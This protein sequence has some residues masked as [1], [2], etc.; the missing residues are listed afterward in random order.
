MRDDRGVALLEVIVAA[1]LLVTLA[2]GASRIIAAAVR[3]GHASRLRAVATASAA[4]KIE[5]VRSLPPGEVAA[6][7]D[8]LDA[9]GTVVGVGIPP[10]RS[11][12]YVRRWST[13]PIDGDPDVVAV[14]VDVSTSDG[15]LR[16]RLT[17]VRAA[18]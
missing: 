16:A 1:A 15:A 18:R 14:R 17:T 12:V 3:E 4:A 2:A 13:Q 7:A 9:G 10:P 8:C 11:A 6:G 5:E